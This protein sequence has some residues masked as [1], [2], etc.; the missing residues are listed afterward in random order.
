MAPLRWAC[1]LSLLVAARSEEAGKGW[2]DGVNEKG[3]KV[4]SLKIEAPSMTEEDQYGYN[5]PDRYKCNSC[6]AVMFH[7]AEDMRKK[8]PQNRRLKEWEYTDAFEETCRSSFSGYGIKLVNGQNVL[9]GPG[10]KD[11]KEIAPGMGAIQMGGESWNKR[12]S[13]ICRKTV[14]ENVG[15]GEFYDHLY[16]RFQSEGA[17]GLKGDSPDSLS[18]CVQLGQCSVGPEAPKKDK[19]A[20]TVVE[21][22]KSKKEKSKEKSKGKEKA[23]EKIKPTK[24]SD[25]KATEAARKN[26]ESPLPGE[27][28]VD[29]QTFLRDLAIRHGLTAEEYLTSRT[30]KEWEKLTLSMASRV[31][32]VAAETKENCPAT[33]R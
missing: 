29:V 31:F 10:I 18:F 14:F 3:Q 16:Q 6:R 2:E 33:G 28:R 17:N 8:Q 11:D 13:E 19:E 32:N 30:F 1:A 24:D 5:M 25:K 12:L 22:G 27:Q 9:S 4:Q 15:E 20:A 21:K 7:L 26:S 23:K